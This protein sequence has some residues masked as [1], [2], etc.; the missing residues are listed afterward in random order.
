MQNVRVKLSTEISWLKTTTNKKDHSL[1][2]Q[3]GIKFIGGL[4]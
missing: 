2:Q 3:I 4:V 1:H